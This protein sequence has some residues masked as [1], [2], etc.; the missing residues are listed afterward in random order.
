MQIILI[1]HLPTKWNMDGLLQGKKDISITKV[2]EDTIKKINENKNRLEEYAPYDAV[3][4][5][6]L[7]RT[8]QT[9]KLHHYNPIMEPLLDELDFGDFEGR[10]KKE[11]HDYF[12]ER[13]I[14]CPETMKLGES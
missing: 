14:Q 6:S 2:S 9:A 4:A 8:N 10:P 12:G 11:L 3:L 1:R 13:W 7:T 5:S